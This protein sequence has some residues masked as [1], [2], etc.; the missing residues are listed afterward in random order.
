MGLDEVRVRGVAD[1][2]DRRWRDEERR[3]ESEEG[4][5]ERGEVAAGAGH[6]MQER[7]GGRGR[8][9]SAGG[10][11]VEREPEEGGGRTGQTWG[12]ECRVYR[13]Q[14]ITESQAKISESRKRKERERVSRWP[15]ADRR[16]ERR[17][18]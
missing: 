18:E 7:R 6:C 10:G 13:V 12:V 9:T 15:M 11:A 5:I 3:G 14:Q 4:E 8:R 2:R 1:P 17:E 16:G